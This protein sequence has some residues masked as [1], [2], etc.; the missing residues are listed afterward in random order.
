MHPRSK[1]DMASGYSPPVDLRDFDPVHF[2]LLLELSGSWLKTQTV[3]GA[4]ALAVEEVN[5]DNSLLAGRVLEYSW[6]DSGCSAEKALKAMGAILK[7]ESRIKA[8]VGP[9][10]RCEA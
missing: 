2:A 8:V 3:A 4:A 7:T 5:A 6:A 1:I 9:G 10:C